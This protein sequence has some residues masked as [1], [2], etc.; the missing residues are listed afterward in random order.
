[1]HFIREFGSLASRGFNVL[2]GGSATTS[3]SARAHYELPRLA[4][5]IDAIFFWQESHC[6]AAFD[7]AV[8]HARYIIDIAEGME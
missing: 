1:M 5:V 6:R 8:A 2:C 4:L 3:L 7:R